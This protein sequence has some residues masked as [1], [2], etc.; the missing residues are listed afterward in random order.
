MEVKMRGISSTRGGSRMVGL[1]TEKE[2][3]KTG[4]MQR[5]PSLYRMGMR[6]PDRPIGEG[7]EM[8]SGVKGPRQATPSG[9]VARPKDAEITKV[10]KVPS[11]PKGNPSATPRGKNL[12]KAY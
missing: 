5:D 3:G 10:T 8:G 9:S 2:H 11:G 1:K 4:W 6:A 7:D 12:G